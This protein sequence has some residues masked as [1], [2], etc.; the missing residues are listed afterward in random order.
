MYIFPFVNRKPL[1]PSNFIQKKNPSCVQ[2]SFFQFFLLI[3]LTLRYTFSYFLSSRE[4][5]KK[6]K[7]KERRYLYIFLSS[8]TLWFEIFKK[9][10][11]LTCA[12]IILPFLYH[13]LFY[14]ILLFR[15]LE[16][17]GGGLIFFFF[18]LN[19]QCCE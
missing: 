15:G 6:G 13:F 4:R 9:Y 5:G 11:S 16:K 10:F 17:V 3:F 19:Y 1:R 8:S 2:F 14:F 12:K 7:K 18:S